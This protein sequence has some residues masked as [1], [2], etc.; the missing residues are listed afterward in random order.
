MKIERISETQMKFILMHTDLEERDI[1]INELSHSSDKTQRLFKE[2]IQLAQDE[3]AFTSES[4]PYKIE[5]MRVG[6]DSLAVMVT[7]LDADDFEKHY[8]LEPAAKGRCRY[9]RNDY[10]D[11]PEYPG[12]DSHSVFSFGSLDMAATACEAICLV[13]Y[14]ESRLYKLDGR[15]CLWL[16]NET[17]DDR[18]TSDLEAILQEFGQKHVSNAISK[19]YLAEH[20]EVIIAEDAVGKLGLYSTI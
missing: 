15:Y 4:T 19:Q 2:I 10:I 16:L 8:N 1:K 13:F 7:K 17:E 6:V 3:G 11:Q 12:E 20:G 14:G 9:K 18:T 5:A